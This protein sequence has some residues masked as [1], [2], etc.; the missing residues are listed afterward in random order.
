M[1]HGKRRSH[2]LLAFSFHIVRKAFDGKMLT[3][4]CFNL[5][6]KDFVAG[7]RRKIVLTRFDIFVSIIPKIAIDCSGFCSGESVI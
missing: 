7:K 4:Y 6:I 3:K 5:G 2:V 1:A